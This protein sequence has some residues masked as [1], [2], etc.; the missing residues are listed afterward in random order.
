MTEPITV[1]RKRLIHR[2][3]YRGCLEADLLL[4]RFADRYVGGFDTGELDRYEAL[5]EESDHDL[6]AWIA[7]RDAVPDR[8]RHELFALLQQFGAA[9]P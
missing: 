6:L 9:G 4:G 5:I 8:H 3:R 7:G 2:S 1:R